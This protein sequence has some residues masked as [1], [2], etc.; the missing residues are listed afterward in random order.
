MNLA[1]LAEEAAQKGSPIRVH[2]TG[3]GKFGFMFLSQVHTIK[4]LEV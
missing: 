3:A 4:G 2:F 1:W